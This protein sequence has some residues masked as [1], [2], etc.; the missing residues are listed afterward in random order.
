[1]FMSSTSITS[2]KIHLSFFNI[3]SQKMLLIF[4]PAASILRNNFIFYFFYFFQLD[5][6]NE[7][8]QSSNPVS[9]SYQFCFTSQYLY[10]TI[11]SSQLLD[12]FFICYLYGNISTWQYLC[13]TEFGCGNI[14]FC[15]VAVNS[16]CNFFRSL[17]FHIIQ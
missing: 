11:F 9:L 5:F 3:E 1:M 15:E 6:C 12:F 13:R 2:D 7:N 17:F 4:I 8:S 16:M 14:I 10:P